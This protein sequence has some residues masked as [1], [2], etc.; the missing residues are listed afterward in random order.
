VEGDAL[1]N[2]KLSSFEAFWP[3]YLSEHRDP[4]N[5]ALHFVGT[6]LVYVL[7]GASALVSFRWLWFAPIVGYGFAWVGHFLVEK[8][9]PATFSY[10][11]WSL[12][13]DFRMH[14][15]TITGRLR[16]DLD[17]AKHRPETSFAA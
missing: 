12:R 15:R 10:P 3:H 2:Q 14:A 17:L 5:R 13:G 9:R 6:S 16:K 1:I 7:I 8:N 4:I 11:L